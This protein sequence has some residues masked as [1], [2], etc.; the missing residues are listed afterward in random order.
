V[1]QS[2]RLTIRPVVPEDTQLILEVYRACEDF[3]ALGPVATAS[4][5]MVEADL[6]LSRNSGGIFCGIYERSTGKMIGVVD[7]VRSGWES[8]PKVAFLE[9]LMIAAPYRSMGFGEE[10]VRLV[11]ADIMRDGLVNQIDSGV[12]VN[13][14]GAVRFWQRMGYE[15]V[16][17]A[18]AMDDGTVAYAL[19]KKI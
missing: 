1:L 19:E 2:E 11:E 12:Q 17:G 13:N 8:N 15:I 3:L 6:A 7:Y 16:S 18:R 9:L 14:P 5:P 4:L 10:I